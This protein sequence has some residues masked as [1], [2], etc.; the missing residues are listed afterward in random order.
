MTDLPLK[1]VNFGVSVGEGIEDGGDVDGERGGDE[2]DEG[3]DGAD[4]GLAATGEQPEANLDDINHGED[5]EDAAQDGSDGGAEHAEA[6]DA[7]VY[8]GTEGLVDVVAVE[9]VDGELEPLRDKAREEEKA[10]RYD[11]EDEEVAGDVEAGVALR[12]PLQAVLARGGDGEPHEDGDGEE[13]IHIH[14]PIEGRH[15]DA[16][17]SAAIV[18]SAT[19][20]A[21]THWGLVPLLLRSIDKSGREK[22]KRKV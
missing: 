8:V 19:A 21:S 9:E 3:G 15:V 4:G 16:G 13:R 1:G 11:L 18:P 6:E 20:A 22:R 12:P 5:E 17:S 10:E 7:G 14:H 2:G